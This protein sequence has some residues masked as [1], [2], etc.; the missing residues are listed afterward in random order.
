MF[1]GQLTSLRRLDVEMGEIA[2]RLRSPL[3]E[4][5]PRLVLIHALAM[6]S[7]QW[8]EFASHVPQDWGLLI[9]DCRAHG[10][11]FG[12]PGPYTIK[13]FSHDLAELMKAIGW[14]K[15][16]VAGCSMG[17]CIAQAMAID[18]PE[19]VE[20]L[21]LIDTTAYYGNHAASKWEQRSTTAIRDGLK[22]LLPFQLERWFTDEFVSANP[23]IVARC[24]DVFIKNNPHHYAEVCKALAE[25]DLRTQLNQIRARTLVIVA[26]HDYATPLSMAQEMAWNI[27]GAEL[28]IL[29]NAKHFAPI[30]CS[31]KVVYFIERFL[32]PVGVGDDI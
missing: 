24:E 16:V 6:D 4:K 17:G 7:S 2:Y 11:S 19:L 5:S 8:T 32:N 9:P 3:T 21:I 27:S 12:P 13:A 28:V 29:K 30:E 10:D 15:S 14:E 1:E 22:A 25:V 20:D 23:E 26:E 31:E 18:Y